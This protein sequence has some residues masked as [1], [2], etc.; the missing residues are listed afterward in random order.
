MVLDKDVE[1]TGHKQ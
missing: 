1:T